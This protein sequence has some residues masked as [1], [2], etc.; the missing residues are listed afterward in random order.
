MDVA[1]PVFGKMR[2][3]NKAT[4]KEVPLSLDRARIGNP[5]KLK[6]LLGAN[7]L[8]KLYN[9]PDQGLLYAGTQFQHKTVK[10]YAFICLNIKNISQATI[11]VCGSHKNFVD[12][13]MF[14]LLELLTP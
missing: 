2:E 3:D 7:G 11:N 4:L 10:H 5:A 9:S 1:E 6:E 13:V 8:I 14:N 12:A